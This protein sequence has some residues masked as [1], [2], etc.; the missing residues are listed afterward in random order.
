M[1]GYGCVRVGNVIRLPLFEAFNVSELLATRLDWNSPPRH[2][3]PQTRCGPARVLHFTTC[4]KGYGH[5]QPYSKQ[6]KLCKVR[7][8]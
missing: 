7:L 2:C 8:G 3:L 1:L 4:V 6:L 5:I